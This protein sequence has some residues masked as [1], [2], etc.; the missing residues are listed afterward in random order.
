MLKLVS[1]C[2]IALSIAIFATTVAAEGQG[3]SQEH[4]PADVVRIV[5]DAL[6]RNP[7]TTDD[8]GI[9]TVWS[10]ASPANRRFTGPLERFSSMIKSGFSDMLGFRSSRF[11]DIEVKGRQ[12]IQVVWLLQAD[13]R[14]LGYA[15]RLS[16]QTGGPFDN[17]WMTEA[18][19][20]LGESERSGTS[21]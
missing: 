7:D 9:K 19:L 13:G 4:S 8:D 1:R 17:M 21:I 20:P 6:Q 14:E 15:F 5:I 18:V 3:P 10:F 16:Q 12:A 11:E 2:A